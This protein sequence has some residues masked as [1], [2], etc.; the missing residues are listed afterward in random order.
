[1]RNF[2]FYSICWILTLGVFNLL[3]FATPSEFNGVSKFTN[4]FWSA[5]AL[6]TIA[7]I[8]Q[9]ICGFFYFKQDEPRR[10]FYNVPVISISFTGLIAMLIVGSI[11]MLIPSIPAWIGAIV[12]LV[13]LAFTAFAITASKAAADAVDATDQKIKTQ[14]FFIKALTV[15][16]SGLMARAQTEIAAEQTKK[17]YE[18]IRYS[19]PMSNEAL[20]GT[21]SQI[22]I[23]FSEF[24]DAVSAGDDSAVQQ[25]A[26]NLLILLQDRNNKCKFLK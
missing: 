6:I 23:L 22:T 5:Y 26:K 25:T 18:A 3:T 19:D 11:F 4:G 14:T 10:R 7:F 16:A 17:V 9:L 15:D 20:S 21:E 13:I 24:S 1:M 2:T 12:C 8:G